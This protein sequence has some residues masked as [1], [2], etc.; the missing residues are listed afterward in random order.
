MRQLF[1]LAMTG[2]AAEPALRPAC[3]IGGIQEYLA[4]IGGS[5]GRAEVLR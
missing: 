4:G 1:A 5:P 2:S 3:P